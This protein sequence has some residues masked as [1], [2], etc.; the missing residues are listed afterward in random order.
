MKHTSIWEAT[1]TL[2]HEGS[3]F[4]MVT[5]ISMRGSAPQDIGAKMIVTTDGLYFGTVGGGKIEAHCIREAA[6][7]LKMNSKLPQ[8]HTWN[9]QSDIGMTC[10][11]EVTYLFEPFFPAEWPIIVFGAGHVAQAVSQ[12]LQTLQCRA[13]FIDPRPEWIEGIANSRKIKK[14]CIEEPATYVQEL[15]KKADADS[16][17]NPYFV[18]M[19]RGHATDMPILKEIY[20][21]FPNAPF[22]GGIGSDVK[23]LKIK[24]ELQES[25]VPAA[26]VEKLH[27]PIGLNLG[28]NDPA[29]IAISVVAQLLQFRDQ[30]LKR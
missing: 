1:Q 10:G 23:A 19:T 9:L 27:C 18:V 15:R 3:P 22:I 8:L 7:V 25:G 26:L 30:T 20:K 24:K 14:L 17:F 4:V 5:L 12:I 6:S 28:G 2:D 21:H 16:K 29:E 13:V 11:G